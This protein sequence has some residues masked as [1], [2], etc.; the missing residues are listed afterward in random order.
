MK[1]ELVTSAAMALEGDKLAKYNAQFQRSVASPLQET[2]APKAPALDG[3]VVLDKY[4]GQDMTVARSMTGA[5]FYSMVGHIKRQEGPRGEALEQELMKITRQA[6]KK[7]RLVDWVTQN[8]GGGVTAP[9]PAVVKPAVNAMENMP[10][11]GT[12]SKSISVA[13]HMAPDLG[14]SRLDLSSA[15]GTE[16]NVGGGAETARGRPNTARPQLGGS[17]M[18]GLLGSSPKGEAPPLTA[19]PSTADAAPTGGAVQDMS[20][21]MAAFVGGRDHLKMSGS[22]YYSLVAWLKSKGHESIEDTLLKVK[23]HQKLQD[24]QSHRAHS[25]HCLRFQ[26]NL[27]QLEHRPSC[28]SVV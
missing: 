1:Q 11:A 12:P 25:Q 7:I 15:M 27:L 21:V 19:R 26:E 23:A 4:I 22:E 14:I 17:A 13:A 24:V 10:P 16:R 6:D 8:I 3:A 5:E 20:V 9:S 28:M 18:A 2:A